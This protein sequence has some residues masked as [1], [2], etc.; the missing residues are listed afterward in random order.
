M[1]E[2]RWIKLEKL[3]TGAIFETRSG[4]RAIKSEYHYPNFN[5]QCVLLAS[6]EYAHF[7]KGDNELVR[8]IRLAEVSEQMKQLES[9]N[10][11]LRESADAVKGLAK[12]CEALHER[13]AA[14]IEAQ[15][16]DI[17]FGTALQFGKEYKEWL[18]ALAAYKQAGGQGGV[19]DGISQENDCHRTK[20]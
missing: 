1:S 10:A 14:W 7:E 4:I 19:S 3:R 18:D 13:Y 20:T 2:N 5:C 9:D 8:E 15:T 12:A 6:G 16:E 11:R 17:Q